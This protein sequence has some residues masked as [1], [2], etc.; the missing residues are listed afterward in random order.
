MKVAIIVYHKN[1]QQLYPVEW[2][3]K[4]RASILMQT[5]QDFDIIE[6]N[7]GGDLFSIFYND[8]NYNVQFTRYK[9]NNFAECM[10]ALLDYAFLNEQYN[11]V[12]NTNIDDYYSPQWLETL[13]TAGKQGYDLVSS[14]FSLVKDDHIVLTHEFHNMIIADELAKDHN[15]I[16]HP[17]VM[18]SKKFWTGFTAT[19]V[20]PFGG[21]SVSVPGNRYNTNEIPLEDLKLWQRVI[22]KS[23]FQFK[24]VPEVLCYHRLHN[25]SVG[26]NLKEQ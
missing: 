19:Q 13:L 23:V 3:N 18:Y 24:I 2:I 14:N 26:H 16:C 6:C 15:I 22:N 8:Q 1:A 4:F 17:A 25:K 10:N 11:F 5:F 12:F 20:G 21:G 9:H 7:Y